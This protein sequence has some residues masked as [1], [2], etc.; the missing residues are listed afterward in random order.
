MLMGAAA[1][2]QVL[3]DCGRDNVF[4]RDDDHLRRWPFDGDDLSKT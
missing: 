4:V 1:V 2:V 3:Q